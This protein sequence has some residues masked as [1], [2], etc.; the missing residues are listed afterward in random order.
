MEAKQGIGGRH[1]RPL[2]DAG[3]EPASGVLLHKLRRPC[4]AS[5][6]ATALLTPGCCLL[7]CFVLQLG[8]SFPSSWAG[9]RLAGPAL[10]PSSST[11]P[12]FL[13]A[14]LAQTKQLFFSWQN[15]IWR[16]SESVFGAL[17]SRR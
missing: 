9:A 2:C 15:F 8:L 6:L 1:G 7:P 10:R 4:T 11:A 17:L 12:H 3:L 16:L 13:A 14:D 5:W